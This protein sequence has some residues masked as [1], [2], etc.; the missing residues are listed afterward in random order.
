M[1]L[2]FRQKTHTKNPALYIQIL[3][4]YKAAIKAQDVGELWRVF[5]SGLL[6]YEQAQVHNKIWLK[7]V[8]TFSTDHRTDEL[9]QP[10]ETHCRS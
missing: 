9:K 1:A 5:M 8:H 4:R 6:T 3:L 10:I 7:I 2:H